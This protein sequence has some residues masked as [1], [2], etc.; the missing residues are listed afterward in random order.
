LSDPRQDLLTQRS[1][2]DAGI[3]EAI[4]ALPDAPEESAR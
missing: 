3:E 4:D 1:E 2:R